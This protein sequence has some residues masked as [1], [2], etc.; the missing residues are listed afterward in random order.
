MNRVNC[1]LVRCLVGARHSTRV[2]CGF[3]VLILAT[4][5]R[6]CRGSVR[7]AAHLVVDLGSGSVHVVN[8]LVHKEVV[9]LF[10]KLATEALLHGFM[11]HLLLL[12]LL[13]TL[14]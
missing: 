5:L 14:G 13:D 7:V 12:E 10:I 11:A 4:L 3:N 9:R 8:E 2:I 6:F 1:D